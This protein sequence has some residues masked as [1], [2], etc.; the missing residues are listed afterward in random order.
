MPANTS[1]PISTVS[2]MRPYQFAK[3]KGVTTQTVYRW[4]RE[5]KI[6]PPRVRKVTVTVSRFEI[7]PSVVI[8][9]QHHAV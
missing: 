2:F 5:G 4:I 6:T 3:K 1:L 9:Q 7:D 8:E